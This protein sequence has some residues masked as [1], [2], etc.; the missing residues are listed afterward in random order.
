LPLRIRPGAPTS[1]LDIAATGRVGLNRIA[2]LAP[3]HVAASAASLGAGNV[4]GLFTNAAGPATLQLVPSGMDPGATPNWNI[5]AANDTVLRI[6]RSGVVTPAFRLNSN[7][8]L[9]VAG[10]LTSSG[11]T[12]GGGC[13]A[14]FDPEAGIPSIADHAMEMWSLG[15]LPNVG[16]T[17]EGEPINV[18]E[19]LGRML[20][21]LE[22]AHI[23]IA[24]L[25]QRLARIEA[26]A[27]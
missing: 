3:L 19:K 23:Y 22:K 21:E 17:P 13:D 1:S 27:E 9:T 8:N 11:P 25:E 2:P 7:G 6:N 24:E 5:I 16:P 20:N 12:C 18:T 14:V 26:A 4:V 10:T 15:Y